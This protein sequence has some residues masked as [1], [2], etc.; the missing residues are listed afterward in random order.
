M[1]MMRR[2]T[3]ADAG[4]GLMVVGSGVGLLFLAL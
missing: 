3:A 1:A 4:N 2:W